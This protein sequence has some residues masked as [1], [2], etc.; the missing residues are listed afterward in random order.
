MQKFFQKMSGL[1]FFTLKISSDINAKTFPLHV[2][3][4][5]REEGIHPERKT[6]ER[7]Q[8]KKSM[9]LKDYR[10]LVSSNHLIEKKC[11]KIS[12][13]RNSTLIKC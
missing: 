5:P 1:I 8:L 10:S 2:T 12:N 7:K 11:N 6:S 3:E 13:I 9:N 4:H